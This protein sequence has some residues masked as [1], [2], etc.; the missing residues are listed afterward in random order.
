MSGNGIVGN[1]TESPSLLVMSAVNEA[2]LWASTSF[3]SEIHQLLTGEAINEESQF[4]VG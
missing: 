2:R 4:L 3:E 1:F